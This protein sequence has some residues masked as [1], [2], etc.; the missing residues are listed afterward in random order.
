MAVP[1]NENKSRHLGSRWFAIKETFILQST[2]L[3]QSPFI[4]ILEPAIDIIIN[5]PYDKMWQSIYSQRHCKLFSTTGG[6]GKGI[7][8]STYTKYRGSVAVL[9]K[10]IMRYRRRSS[11]AVS[12]L[13][14]RIPSVET[15]HTRIIIFLIDSGGKLP[16]RLSLWNNTR[17]G[18]I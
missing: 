13:I 8:F 9:W 2:Y 3:W 5:A 4:D 17:Q 18:C 16:N 14:C 10:T 6:W 1:L 7:D 12:Q 11:P 15:F